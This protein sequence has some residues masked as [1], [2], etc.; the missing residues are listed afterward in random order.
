FRSAEADSLYNYD[1]DRSTESAQ[2]GGISGLSYRLSPGH[3]IHVRGLYTNSADDE[4]RVNE[5]IN[6]PR[7]EGRQTGV[8]YIGHR[9]TRLMYVQRNIL[10]GT[11]EGQHDLSK[12]WGAS[13]DWKVTRSRANR[14]QPDRR[15][16]TYDQRYYFEGDTA[17][18]TIGS[19]AQRE[20]GDLRD[21]GW[22]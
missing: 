10:S 8:G 4:V 14:L 22:G 3:S 2:L 6:Y 7:D 19:R 20:F 18:W 11:V 16:V 15:E 21:N 5:G 12:L 17:H 9:Y 1:V 13:L